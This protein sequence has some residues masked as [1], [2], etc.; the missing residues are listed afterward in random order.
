MTQ[1]NKET[2]FQSKASKK[3]AHIH[4]ISNKQTK[5]N[6]V[7]GVPIKFDKITKKEIANSRRDITSLVA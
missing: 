4:K 1:T 6:V 3:N 2:I 7:R 5:K